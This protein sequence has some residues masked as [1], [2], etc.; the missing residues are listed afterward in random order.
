MSEVANR[1]R[2]SISAGAYE[3]AYSIGYDALQEPKCDR[4]EIVTLLCELT[5]QLRHKCMSLAIKKM[6]DGEAYEKF[7]KLLNRANKLTGQDIYGVFKT[8]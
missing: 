3:D 2:V 1:M 5:A 6:D 4:D 8:K 7:E